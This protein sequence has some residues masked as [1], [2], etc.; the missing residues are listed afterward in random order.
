MDVEVAN[1]WPKGPKASQ[2]KALLAGYI[3]AG[4][5]NTLDAAAA[6]VTTEGVNAVLEA[7]NGK[8]LVKSRWL[9]G[10]D[11]AISQP[12]AIALIRSLSNASLRV[13]SFAG[14]GARFHT[15]MIHLPSAKKG[16]RSVLMVGSANISRA[17]F[18]KNAEGVSFISSES[19]FEDKMLV[20]KF[21]EVW[22]L[23][24]VPSDA[25]L[26]TYDAR[27][28]AA[29]KIRK[30]LEK[31]TIG[32][33]TTPNLLETPDEIQ[34]DPSL[35]NT[36]WIECGKITLMGKELELKGI[37]ARFFGL[38][39]SGVHGTISM[40]NLRHKN[41]SI[42]NTRFKFDTNSMWRVLFPSAIPEIVS[43]L[44]PK[45]KNGKLGRSPYVAVFRKTKASGLFDLEFL[46]ETDKRYEALKQRSLDEGAIGDTG[47]RLFGWF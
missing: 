27:Y 26:K 39:P 19:A 14:Q 11:D 10:L 28:H 41:G 3:T 23:G 43:G 16:G 22:N 34:L 1:Q 30:E 2:L 17:A 46:H 21:D 6:Y 7:L 13:V 25:E 4:D 31:L 44:R 35:A 5:C 20:A 36:C 33:N 24:H 45:D 9:V 40:I 12:G 42:Y 18:E 47:K 29:R 15:K 32:K 38:L 37:Q 8:N